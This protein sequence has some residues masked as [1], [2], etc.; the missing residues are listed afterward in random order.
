MR[1]VRSELV[2]LRRPGYLL[3]WFGLTAVFAALINVVMFQVGSEQGG[4][5]EG[6]GVSFPTVDALLAADGIVAGLGAGASMFGVVALSFWAIAA[7]S[8]H[9]T[10]LIRLLAAAEPRRWVLIVGKWVSLAVVTAAATLVALV[11]N[12]AVAPVAAASAGVEPTAWGTDIVTIA[13]GAALDLY[14]AL[15]VWGTIGLAL[16]VLARSAGIAIG[17]GVGWVLLLEGV[18]SAAVA[19]IG[20]WMPGATI[21]ALATGGSSSITF[22]TALALGAAYAG[23]A[24]AATLVTSTRRDITD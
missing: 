11:V 21:G 8:D 5:Q 9:S 19:D 4:P 20:D 15:L 17:V 24:M 16:A 7:A 22:G 6:P 18:I 3:G 10:G 12:V 2:R 23:V 1:A 14:L 13:L